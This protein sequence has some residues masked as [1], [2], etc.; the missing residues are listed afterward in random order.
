LQKYNG[1]SMLKNK[2]QILVAIEAFWD[3]GQEYVV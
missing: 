2:Q 3:D 1:V